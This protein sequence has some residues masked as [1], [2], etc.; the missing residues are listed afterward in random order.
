MRN[1][2]QRLEEDVAERER[3][4][5][6]IQRAED[7]KSRREEIRIAEREAR[8]KFKESEKEWP[9]ILEERRRLEQGILPP[10]HQALID[11]AIENAQRK[12]E[13][14]MAQSMAEFINKRSGM[15]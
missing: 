13:E 10:E 11:E 4:K 6:S 1:E 2:R 9:K 8:A 3:L 15:F 14:V 5:A 12:M 7:L